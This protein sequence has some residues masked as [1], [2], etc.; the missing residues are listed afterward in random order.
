MPK[1]CKCC[2]SLSCSLI[3]IADSVTIVFGTTTTGNLGQGDC[4]DSASFVYC[5]PPNCD[6]EYYGLLIPFPPINE[7]NRDATSGDCPKYDG[8]YV[9]DV[10]KRPFGG[11]SMLRTWIS[12][13]YAGGCPE[14]PPNSGGIIRGTFRWVNT[15]GFTVGCDSITASHTLQGFLF[16]KSWIT[17]IIRVPAGDAVPPYPCFIKGDVTRCGEEISAPT[18]VGSDGVF[19]WYKRTYSWMVFA[20]CNG[21]ADDYGIVRL[22]TE[23]PGEPL[24]VCGVSPP[25]ITLA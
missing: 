21:S 2:N 6:N 20:R 13:M 3:N 12:C 14:S 22:P 4:R 10:L 23:I 8:T 7:P 5:P 24:Y 11:E 15:L 18:K 25:Q 16:R 19:D 9:V 1:I 17:D